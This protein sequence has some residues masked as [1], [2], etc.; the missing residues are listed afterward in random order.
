MI[1]ATNA[2]NINMCTYSTYKAT[3]AIAAD[4]TVCSGVLSEASKRKRLQEL[5]VT[6]LTGPPP[7]LR[8]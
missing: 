3:A 5:R 6:V 8:C 2:N 1:V 4:G 7:K